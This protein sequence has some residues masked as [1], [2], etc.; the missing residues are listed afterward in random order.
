MD[1]YISSGE[2]NRYTAP[3][4]GVVTGVPKQIGQIVVVP[5]TTAAQTVQFE[6][7]TRGVFKVTKV[8]SQAWT[9]GALVY[10]DEGN[11]RAT[12]VGPGSIRIGHA[13]LGPG[14]L[15]M[16]GSGAG[17]TTGYV[18]FDGVAGDTGT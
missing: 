8:G 15:A 3:S 10:W 16:P 11:D 5:T 2:V 4:G 1:N 14:G 6:G 17:E 7:M 9:E 18:H 12:T 13:V